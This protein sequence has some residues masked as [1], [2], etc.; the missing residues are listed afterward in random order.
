M[1]IRTHIVAALLSIASITSACEAGE[2]GEELEPRSLE[3][4]EIDGHFTIEAGRFVFD[5]EAKRAFDY[6][7]TTSGELE[8]EDLDA[9]VAAQVRA[10]IGPRERVHA[11]IMD[12]WQRYLGFR[13]EA[14][15][16]LSPVSDGEPLDLAALEHGLLTSLDVHLGD[17]PI[18]AHERVRITHGLAIHQAQQLD[19]LDLR[20]AR[21]AELSELE[22]QRFADSTAGRYLV[23][24]QAIVQA[25]AAGAELETIA[26]LR[27]EHFDA[28]SPGAAERLAALDARRAE[29]DARVSAFQT[30]RAELELR[31][32][33]AD[34]LELELTEL[35]DGAFTT[36]EQRRLNVLGEL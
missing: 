9:W 11:Q 36:A 18:A 31:S 6:F 26:G 35:R 10:Q 16:L 15:E 29:W 33:S 24:R 32:L 3:G 17:A 4:T 30:A 19:D 2:P 27:A 8:P 1:N 20:Q 34:Q 7:L 22:T 25:Q 21:L 14:A 13:T 12:A 5:S 28:I 23:G